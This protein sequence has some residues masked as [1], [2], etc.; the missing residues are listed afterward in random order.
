MKENRYIDNED[1]FF[2]E[3]T[4]RQMLGAFIVSVALFFGVLIYLA[5]Q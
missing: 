5:N 3:V 1:D 2:V 4:D